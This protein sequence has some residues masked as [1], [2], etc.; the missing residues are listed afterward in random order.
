MRDNKGLA[1]NKVQP[2]K[3]GTMYLQ[4]IVDTQS[5]HV[6][7]VTVWSHTVLQYFNANFKLGCPKD[8]HYKTSRL[9]PTLITLIGVVHV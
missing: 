2:I 8:H 3:S 4:I 6:V 7:W 5:T 9:L 1:I